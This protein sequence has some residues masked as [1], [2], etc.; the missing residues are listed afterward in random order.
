MSE[1]QSNA[2]P[3]VKKQSLMQW[4]WKEIIMPFGSAIFAI[5]FFLQAF[6]IPSSSMEDTLL[7]NDF[8]LGL[9]FPYGSNVP[10]SESRVP[11]FMDPQTGDVLIFKYPGDPQIPDNN[12]QRYTH[13][14]NLLFLGNWYWD[15]Q[16]PEGKFPL[17]HYVEGPREFIKRCV[18]QSGQ[19]VEIRNKVLYVDGQAQMPL[20]GKGKMLNAEVK[21]LQ[22]RDM[23][24]PVKLPSPGQSFG[25]DTLKIADL[26]RMRSLMTQENPGHRFELDLK[27]MIDGRE[28]SDHLFNDMLFPRF[29]LNRFGDTVETY[30]PSFVLY[31][32]L[33]IR[34][35]LHPDT[36]GDYAFSGELQ[37]SDNLFDDGILMHMPFKYF[38]DQA[39]LG[40]NPILIPRDDEQFRY[41]SPYGTAQDEHGKIRKLSYSYFNVQDLILLERYVNLH[42]QMR[43]DRL[44]KDSIAGI[45]TPALPEY[46]IVARILK[47]GQP[48]SQYTVQDKVYFM[49]GDNRDNSEDS[50]FW[51]FVARRSVSAKAFI[52]Y[53]SYENRA[54]DEF[55]FSLTNP[56]SWPM[57]FAQIRWTRIGKLIH[58]L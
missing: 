44:T 10:W 52:I 31:R 37:K 15:K 42:N 21:N 54:P 17:V 43:L 41:L 51:G 24:G 9:K 3:E 23:Y 8:L 55:Q 18:A 38:A 25:L 4:W 49:M 1:V 30:K 12:P 33:K 47:D 39:R 6:K 16:A 58:G 19:T 48:I 29:Q 45:S 27:L 7:I 46:K 36:T 56:L 13:L 2:Q 20:P 53:F 11:G 34:R 26:Y 32:Y 57:I 22:F 50:R 14:V 40:H 35:G 5:V 28:A